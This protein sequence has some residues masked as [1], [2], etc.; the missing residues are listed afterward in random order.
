MIVHHFNELL[1]FI[2]LGLHIPDPSDMKSN[3]NKA[4]LKWYDAVTCVLMFSYWIGDVVGGN[5]WVEVRPF[6]DF[7]TKEKGKD[8]D[9]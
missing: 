1:F 5:C 8:F 6:P 2:I 3:E 4:E 9:I 7:Q